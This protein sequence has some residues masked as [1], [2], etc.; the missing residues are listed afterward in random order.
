MRLVRGRRGIL[1]SSMGVRHV[2][3]LPVA[4]L[5]SMSSSVLVDKTPNP[6]SRRFMQI[7]GKEV[8]GWGSSTINIMKGAEQSSLG[9][10]DKIVEEL[11]DIDGVEGVFFGPD[12][13]TIS[14][15][16]EDSWEDVEKSASNALDRA[17]Q[18]PEETFARDD[19]PGNSSEEAD[20][21]VELILEVLEARVRP[22][23]QSDGGDVTFHSFE[24]ETGT[25]WLQ[26]LGACA[27]CPSST[28]TLRYNVQ[29]VMN[30][31]VPEVKQVKRKDID[32][33]SGPYQNDPNWIG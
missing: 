3:A 31:Y 10:I 15:E 6:L 22:Y 23:A 20:E 27:S 9:Q 30:H 5:R 26:M 11:F 8:L 12:Y 19:A 7:D 14:V 17:F 24:K 4:L 1:F 13:V 21:V 32:D 25:L 29:N 16:N 2:P 28:I 18:A 33:M